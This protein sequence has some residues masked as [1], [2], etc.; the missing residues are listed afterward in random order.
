[1]DVAA[2]VN[3]TIRSAGIA[4]SA[5]NCWKALERMRI[6]LLQV[7]R[8]SH[9]AARGGQHDRAHEKKAPSFPT[10]ARTPQRSGSRNSP[11]R[12]REKLE[13]QANT[14]LS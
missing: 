14:E 9:A 13:R 11:P 2:A 5:D 1:M 6:I 8:L 12:R 3:N 4:A 7:R 10:P